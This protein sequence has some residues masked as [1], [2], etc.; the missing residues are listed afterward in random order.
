MWRN[1]KVEVQANACGRPAV[2]KD[3]DIRKCNEHSCAR[4]RDCKMSG[5]SKWTPCSCTAD[6]VKRRSRSILTYG[7]GN[8]EFCAGHTKE[9]TGCNAAH[10]AIHLAVSCKLEPWSPWG[11]CSV[12][13]GVGIHHRDRDVMVP[14]SNGG[15]MCQ[16]ALSEQR[17]CL[18]TA[19]HKGAGPQ[20]CQWSQWMAWGACDKCG[21]QRKRIRGILRMAE[22]G[23]TPC[24]LTSTEE[25]SNCTRGCH[26]TVF[27]GWGPWENEGECSVTCGTGAQKRTR[28]LQARIPRDDPA[29]LFE[30][31]GMH[32]R[33]KALDDNRRREVVLSFLCGGLVSFAA[34][35]VTLGTVRL[36][37]GSI[38][39]RTLGAPALG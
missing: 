19:C 25:T 5:W 14:A 1:R 4:D 38:G 6:G 22:A 16:G 27:C 18:V 39:Y 12:S 21:G 8:G 2:G 31:N 29:A 15:E 13:C 33:L 36:R 28:Y 9:I 24:S 32:P 34:V 30:Q 20:P 10:Q 23:G 7:S 37:N 11:D 17:Q 35:L 26:D 3:K